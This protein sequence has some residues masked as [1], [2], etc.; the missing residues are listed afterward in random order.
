V[1]LRQIRGR[2]TCV[3]LITILA[4]F[5]SHAAPPDGN[6]SVTLDQLMATLRAVQHVEARYVERHSLHTLR[7]P[8]ETRGTLR[9]DAPDHL[10]KTADPGPAGAPAGR[11]DRITIDANRLTIDRGPDASPIVLMLNEHPE[12]GVL[13]ESIRATLSGDGQA[14][15]RVFDVALAG[16]LA[17]W[18][19]VLQP[20]DPGQREILQWMRITGDGD[21]I[22]AIDT[23]QGDGDH[24]EMTITEP[25]R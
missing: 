10:E 25:A 5:Q 9:F 4:A 21:R 15:R 2:V 16:S 20:H 14:L 19:M 12:I 11:S 18:Q 8:I 6:A 24:A 22:V 23:Q 7:T 17:H 13:V 1:T 3:A